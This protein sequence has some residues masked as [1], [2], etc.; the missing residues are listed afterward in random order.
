M[1]KMILA[2]VALMVPLMAA[3]PA[4]A[5]S[6]ERLCVNNRAIK[7]SR[8]SENGY[9]VKVGD[10]WYVNAA[11]GCPLFASDRAVR[12]QGVTNRQCKGDQVDIFQ[13]VT[14]L[15]FG[16]CTLEAWQPVAEA[17]VPKN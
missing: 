9:F 12:V 11:N 13:T 4:F 7:A 3:G 16:A 17:A 5:E 10:S 2:V 6:E 8:F 1:R 14:V 15:G